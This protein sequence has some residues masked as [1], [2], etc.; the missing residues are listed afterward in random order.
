MTMTSPK[1]SSFA[2][3]CLIGALMT[4]AVTAQKKAPKPVPDKEVAEK[5]EQ[6]IKIAK[7]KKFTE[8]ARGIEVIDVLMQ[9]QDKGLIDKDRAMVVKAL[10][11]VLNKNKVRP[12]DNVRLY[13]A[14]AEALGR[15]GKDGAKALKKAFE[16][17]NRFKAKPMWVP[18]RERLLKNIGRA[19]DEAN[20]KFLIDEAR[21]NPE[22]ALQAAAGDA[23]GFFEKSDEKIRKEIVSELL[24]RFGSLSEEA[25]QGG[26]SVDSQ[27]ARDRL[28]AISG[29]W[30][31]T[32]K[33]LSGQNFDSFRD[34][35]S[36]FQKNKNKKW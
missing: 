10:D 30:V 9:K 7:N 5:V 22:A 19:K 4:P 34:W 32:L 13:N 3:L 23:L 12:A 35:Q 15:H 16:N 2:V 11:G 8:D 20:I 29:K 14:A 27:N 21:R 28:A 25:S 24:K 31:A 26:T 33:K 6:L 18:M 1:P 17:K 36:W